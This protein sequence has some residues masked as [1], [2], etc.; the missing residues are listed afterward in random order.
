MLTGKNRPRW[1][2]RDARGRQPKCDA[3]FYCERYDL[4]NPP[5]GWRR[6]E[7]IAKGS[8]QRCKLHALQGARHCHKHTGY[9][10][11][12]VAA[13][14]DWSMASMRSVPR[15]ALAR[16]GS[17]EAPRDMD[18]VPY[19]A[20]PIDRGRLYE[21]WWNRELAPH[22]WRIERTKA[23]EKAESGGAEGRPPRRRQP[24]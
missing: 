4:H 15:Q 22:V 14:V 18:Y 5:E 7:A 21:A 3:R 16:I 24:R 8:G 17:G 19:Q 6:C 10:A 1:M 9:S 20:S 13:G 23:F 12:Y 11:A 2:P